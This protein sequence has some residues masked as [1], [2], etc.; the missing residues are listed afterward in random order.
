MLLLAL[1]ACGTP[2]VEDPVEEPITA[3]FATY[4]VSMYRNA[5]GALITGLGD[6][7][8]EQ[9]RYAAAVL[10]DVRPDVLLLNEVDYDANGA[11]V[12]AFIDGFL[13]VG[14]E[15][16]E[17]L[18]Y[19]HVYIPETNT[20]EHSGFD[21]DND[22]VI[23]STPGSAAYGGD[24]WGFGQYPGQ[25]GMAV[26]SQHPIDT[27]NIRT[28][29]KLVWSD[30]PDAWLPEGWYDS[31]ETAAMRLS[32]KTH[33]DV[34]VQIGD[35]TVH[36]LISHPTP[37]TFDGDEDRNGRRNHDEIRFWAEYVS[38]EW[39]SDDN[40]TSGGL[41]DAPFVIAGDLNADPNDGDSS[42]APM[43]LLL[44]HDRIQGSPAPT[45]EGAAEQAT[46]Q[47]G[48]NDSHT[49]SAAED[50]T[51]FNDGSVGNLRIDYV[52][53]STELR[54]VD[55]GVFWPLSSDPRFEWVGR[56][57]FPVSDHRLVW[58]D[59]EVEQ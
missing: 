37:P 30:M 16:Q 32:S 31:D 48:A 55:S 3:R 42:N 44:D 53:P 40:G 7:T 52:L 4:N 5:E 19:P 9:A 15:G 12:Q 1:L 33:A 35:E 18:A 28:F 43:R 49:G 14:Q 45:S 11:A 38:A 20:G 46:A 56:N 13:A 21:L 29:R 34:P 36:F 57:P 17:P 24:A 25:Y 27:T 54:R 6:T 47:G 22:G 39:M 59:V 8:L 2:P 10:Q 26:L 51:D 23:T 41:G 50:T 58:V